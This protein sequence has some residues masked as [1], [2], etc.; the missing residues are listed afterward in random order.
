MAQ[1][2]VIPT[3]NLAL[4]KRSEEAVHIP[5]Q[6]DN[7][8]SILAM[9]EAMAAAMDAKAESIRELGDGNLENLRAQFLED[10]A[11]AIRTGFDVP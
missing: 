11:D 8:S 2:K 1:K 9:L 6:D 10:V 4:Q 7:P 5:P 3:S